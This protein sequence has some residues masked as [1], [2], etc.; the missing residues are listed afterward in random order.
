[1]LET[2]AAIVEKCP[3]GVTVTTLHQLGY[4]DKNQPDNHRMC[5]IADLFHELERRGSYIT[6]EEP[7][8]DLRIRSHQ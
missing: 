4:G 5:D 8:G 6:T 3:N 2:I 7:N 1:M